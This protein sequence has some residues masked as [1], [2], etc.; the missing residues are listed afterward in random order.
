MKPKKEQPIPLPK[1]SVLAFNPE[2]KKFPKALAIYESS[3]GALVSNSDY[4]VFDPFTGAVMTKL[5]EHSGPAN[6]HNRKKYKCGWC[7]VI[8]HANCEITTCIVCGTASRTF[9]DD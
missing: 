8:M 4:Q 5:G 6:M 1:F 7:S 9:R 3:R 2:T